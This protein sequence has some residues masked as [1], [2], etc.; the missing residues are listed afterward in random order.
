M[1]EVASPPLLRAERLRR[2]ADDGTLLLDDVSLAI[3]PGESVAIVGPPGAGKSLLLRSLALL[4][5]IESGEVTLNGVLISDD[6]VPDFRSHVVYVQQRPMLTEGTVREN[7][8]L[9]FAFASHREQ[10][11]EESSIIEWLKSMGRDSGFLERTIADLSGGESQV[12]ALIRALQLGPQVLLLDEPTSSLDPHT[13]SQVETLLKR[14]MSENG[15][16]SMVIVTH[17]ESQA[18]RMSNRCVRLSGG[19]VVGGSP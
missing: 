13:S 1:T 18:T 8:Q 12:V 2:R 7:L 19:R 11:F 3:S 17:N 6:G 16:R 4:D 9:P 10:T 15:K 14:W 5:P